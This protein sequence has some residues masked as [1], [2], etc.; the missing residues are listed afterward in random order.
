[1]SGFRE[2]RVHAAD[3][4][5]RARD[6]P[7]K[8]TLTYEGSL[9]TGGRV[10]DQKHAR[11]KV[12]HNQLKRLWKVHPLLSR[13]HMPI[14]QYMAAPAQDVLQAKHAKIGAFK[15]VPLITEDLS[16]EAALNF[17]I[18][19]PS[20]FKGNRADQDNIV[21][22][23]NDS[24]KMPQTTGDL[25]GGA[26]P[27]DGEVPFFVLM[28]DDGLLSKITS[29]ADELLQPVNGKDEIERDDARLFIDVYIRP[30]YPNNTNLIFFSDDFEIWNYRWADGIFDQIRGWSN[31]ELRGRVTQC[32]LRMRVTESNFRM[33][34]SDLFARRR[35]SFD[36]QT[37]VA[38]YADEQWM[39][40]NGNLR[41]VASAL[42]EELQR[43]VYGEPPYPVN[44]LLMAVETGSLAGGDAIGNAATALESLM[45]QLS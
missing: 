8:F 38:D 17:H 13:W 5:F 39:I 2:V 21:K 35:S 20:D 4:D 18:L 12:F 27:G 23:V 34:R 29:T 45:R 24:L 36:M 40:W 6:C 31:A 3:Y 43:R 9:K 30:N 11:R 16:V 42:L 14:N 1:M 7:L 19:R 26:S 37:R 15:F 33:Q 22:V 10:A 41:P 44:D 32:I 25:P 28:Q